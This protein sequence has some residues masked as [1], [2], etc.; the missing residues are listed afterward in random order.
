MGLVSAKEK[1]MKGIEGAASQYLCGC[2]RQ[3]LVW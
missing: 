3:N 1:A 2:W